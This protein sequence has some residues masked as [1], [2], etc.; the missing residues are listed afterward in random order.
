MKK[1]L[2][3]LIVIFFGALAFYFI[4]HERKRSHELEAVAAANDSLATRVAWLVEAA[5]SL[6][7]SSDRLPAGNPE[8]TAGYITAL[9]YLDEARATAA[10]ANPPMPDPVAR[11]SIDRLRANLSILDSLLHRQ[12]AVVEGMPSAQQQIRSQIARI[13]SALQQ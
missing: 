13:D 8:E 5:D 3:L 10:K 1:T 4:G 2:I 12:L 7:S 9:R 11:Q 6:E